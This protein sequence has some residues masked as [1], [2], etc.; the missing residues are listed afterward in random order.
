MRTRQVSKIG[1]CAGLSACSRAERQQVDL[2][3][4]RREAHEAK[5]DMHH[6][7]IASD[8]GIGHHCH[9]PRAKL[10]G[11]TARSMTRGH[12]A[13]MQC[14]HYTAL[15]VALGAAAL[16]LSP[17]PRAA[18]ARGVVCSAGLMIIATRAG[19]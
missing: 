15:V 13:R 7:A 6:R 1:Q 9:S 19:Q 8:T 5:S 10:G 14:I 16:P 2:S 4:H 18:Y 11:V 17:R 3:A 12:V